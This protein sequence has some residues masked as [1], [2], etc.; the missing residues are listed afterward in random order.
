MY[1]SE[2][3]YMHRVQLVSLQKRNWQ[4]QSLH[5][6]HSLLLEAHEECIHIDRPLSINLLQHGVQQ[7][8]GAG[9]CVTLCVYCAYG[10]C[11]YSEIC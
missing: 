1:E 8:E 10:V 7:D 9:V 2:H 4:Y 6:V 5:H 11:L 3:S